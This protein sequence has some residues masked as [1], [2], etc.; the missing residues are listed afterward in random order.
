MRYDAFISYSHAADGKLAPKLQQA[1]HN[2]AKPW[3]RR[4][5]LRVF[6]DATSLAANPAL[7]PA[8]EAALANSSWFLY[9]A[10][11]DAANSHWVQKEI[12]WWLEH[13]SI[14]RML[15]LLTEG[16]LKWHK[17]L[18]DFDW[19]ATT[20]VPLDL[21]GHFPDEPLYV[22][23]RWARAED[24]LSARHSRFRAALLDIAAPL[25]GIPKEDLDGEDVRVHRRNKIWAWSA[26][27]ALVLL[28]VV[29][30]GA[31]VFAFQQRN[32]AIRQRDAAVAR[33]LRS[34]AQRLALVDRQWSL[35]L[36]LMVESMRHARD[37][38]SYE[39]LWRLTQGG[40]RPVTRHVGKQGYTP[41]AF[42]PD[43]RWLAFDE[44]RE[45]VILEARS[46]KV[47]QRIPLDE[48]VHAVRFVAGN[49]RIIVLGDP[50]AQVFDVSSGRSIARLDDGTRPQIYALSSGT[51]Y[52]AM[53][54]G[55]TVRIVNLLTASDVRTVQ[56]AH[57][58]TRVEILDSNAERL[59]LVN[60][61]EAWLTEAAT[62][63]QVRLPERSGAIGS[64]AVS[65]KRLAVASY[66]K[67]DPVLVLD[68]QSG[69]ESERLAPGS[70][71]ASLSPNGDLLATNAN[72]EHL[73]VRDLRRGFDVA[74]IKLPGGLRALHWSG[75][76]ELLVA[77]TERRSQVL[78]LQ[79]G[80]WRQ[81]ARLTYGLEGLAVSPQG[82]LFAGRAGGGV[83][84]FRAHDG[85]PWLRM[86][87]LGAWKK[88][89][90]SRD[91]RVAAG[92]DSD[93]TI[94]VVEA[95][96]NRQ[97][98]RLKVCE[99]V[100]ALSLS[101]RGERIAVKCSNGPVIVADTATGKPGVSLAHSSA[102]PIVLSPDGRLLLAIADGAR[103]VDTASG[104]E[105]RTFENEVISAAAFS[106]DRKYLLVGA[107]RA[108]LLDL[109]G[110]GDYDFNV[111]NVDSVEFSADGT[112]LAVGARSRLLS[113]YDVRTKRRVALLDHKEEEQAV[114]RIQSI[115][116]DAAATRLATV[117]RN[118]TLEPEKQ[119]GTLR[120]FDI[121]AQ[122][123]LL[124][125][126]IGEIPALLRFSSDGQAL[127][128]TSG[129]ENVRLER[130]PLQ[131]D[132]LIADACDRV[133][134]NL[135]AEEWARYF[136]GAAYRPT[137][138]KLNS[139]APDIAGE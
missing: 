22:D 16:E 8:I 121:R 69:H 129:M 98:A 120:V 28:A 35:A 137:C 2:F 80:S 104:R 65:A 72:W 21:R 62:G 111:E 26:G 67:G 114:L 77:A 15:V 23:L 12:Q 33:Q 41:L 27:T 135:T 99:R 43:G 138:P 75:D 102:V 60:E 51:N 97:R 79:Q 83:I 84:V 71:L 20:A 118:P 78:A 38:G 7:W 116:F 32:E 6:R 9:L 39:M 108:R 82:D 19:S 101:A 93:G 107:G 68:A 124:R 94:V 132:D 139:A 52:L 123:E 53:A 88:L 5:A 76:G 87:P 48:N 117:T 130:I 125:A 113:V 126:P 86:P 63:R 81:I 40:A 37:A 115:V 1:L 57:P 128:F 11:P 47:A 36:L 119:G 112:L 34:E 14:D 92:V 122:T 74:R 46:A 131:P 61:K 55:S 42:S 91:G 45:V 56:S 17:T 18:R 58:F 133:G 100:F 49:D 66:G 30:S 73:D 96:T 103:V 109:A 136:P 24:S 4:R 134:R 127:E 106:P 90:L 29:A 50:L 31:A 25:R 10:S 44:D 70:S 64:L 54:K 13:R 89:V 105:I 95:Q 85:V 3:Y 110:A 59:A